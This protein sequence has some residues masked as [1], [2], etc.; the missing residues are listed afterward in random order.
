MRNVGVALVVL[1]IVSLMLG[2]LNA[3]TAPDV[4]YVV[5]SMLPGTVFLILGLWLHRRRD[6]PERKYAV[7]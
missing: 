7:K 5:G 4:A 6:E 1:G 2:G 3:R